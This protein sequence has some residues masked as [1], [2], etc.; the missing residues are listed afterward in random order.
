MKKRLLKLIECKKCWQDFKLH[1]FKEENKEIKDG[2]LVCPQCNNYYSIVNFIPR[3]LP[4]KFYYNSKF[5][6]FY[7]QQIKKIVK[8]Y[9]FEEDKDF[10]KKLKQDNIKFF[11]YEWVHFD[12]HGFDDRIYHEK[13]EKNIFHEKTLLRT[14][15]LNNKLVL[16]AG[17]GNG[18]YTYQALCCGAE[19]VGFDL[20]PGVES[21][22]HNTAQF[23][24]AHIIQSDI[25]NLPFK[26]EVFDIAFTIGVIHHT[27]NSKRA[28]YS[29]LSPLKINGTLAV[30]C[31][32]K[33][34]FIWEFNDWWI[35]LITTRMS[36]PK[37]MKLS[38]FLAKSCLF[39]GLA[40]EKPVNLLFRWEPNV[41]IMYDWYSAPIAHHHT[42]PEVYSWCKQFGINL[43]EDL[44]WEKRE[45]IRNIRWVR[46]FVAPDWAITVRGIK[47]GEKVVKLRPKHIYDKKKVSWDD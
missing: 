23:P 13:F 6:L 32:H 7:H 35:R 37:L 30:T 28:F 3:I 1:V 46:K 11:G 25:F 20:G 36:I 33:G 39:C 5:E 27:G 2:L 44:R 43:T 18:R 19:V 31:Y 14:K 29:L 12:R 9:Q 24:K 45:W 47:S 10:F 26:N 21:A 42:Y 15:E 34:N 38:N 8:D 41:S 22:Y 4:K 16:D 17:C 40:I